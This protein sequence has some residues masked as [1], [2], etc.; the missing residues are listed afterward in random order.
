MQLRYINKQPPLIVVLSCSV[1]VWCG[2][3]NK[4]PVGVLLLSAGVKAGE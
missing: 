3:I 4:Q 2:V 1:V